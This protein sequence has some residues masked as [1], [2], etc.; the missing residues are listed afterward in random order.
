TDQPL[1]LDGAHSTS[2]RV[3][4]SGNVQN[5]QYAFQNSA[6]SF[7]APAGRGLIGDLQGV[8][9]LFAGHVNRSKSRWREED[10]EGAS[11]VF[12]SASSR[13][14]RRMMLS[15]SITWSTPEAVMAR[16][17]LSKR[18]IQPFCRRYHIR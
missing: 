12:L 3:S 7:K 9:P 1:Q 8:R 16:W 10:E 2:D 13:S 5:R 15:C 18:S 17:P 6:I 4:A 14:R 11:G